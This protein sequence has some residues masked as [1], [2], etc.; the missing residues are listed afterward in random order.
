[1]VDSFVFGFKTRKSENESKRSFFTDN[2]IIGRR[3]TT[4]APYLHRGRPKSLL[5]LEQK[6]PLLLRNIGLAWRRVIYTDSNYGL[7]LFVN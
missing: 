7:V 6:V 2:R 3:T 5:G 4:Y 1:M